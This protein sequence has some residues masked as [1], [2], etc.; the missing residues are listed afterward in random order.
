MAEYSRIVTKDH[1]FREMTNN[2]KGALPKIIR[3]AELEASTMRNLYMILLDLQDNV[4][5]G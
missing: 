3:V 2:W 5:F 1:A 4:S